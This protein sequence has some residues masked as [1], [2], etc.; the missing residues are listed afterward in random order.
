M[1]TKMWPSLHNVNYVPVTM[2]AGL[3][4]LSICE[5]EKAKEK[6]D[7]DS[8]TQTQ[9]LHANQVKLASATP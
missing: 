1:R 9:R 2:H 5:N 3:G 7:S 4:K 8:M 6:L